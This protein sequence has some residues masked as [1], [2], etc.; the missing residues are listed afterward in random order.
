MVSQD[1]RDPN[2]F[3]VSLLEGLRERVG[4][5]APLEEDVLPARAARKSL[6]FG[7]LIGLAAAAGAAWYILGSGGQPASGPQEVPVV[8]AEKAPVKVR[9]ADPGGMDVPN[10]DKLVYNRVDQNAVKPE[11]EHLLP[12]P[13]QPKDLPRSGD[14]L[15]DGMTPLPPPIPETAPK[16][17]DTPKVVPPPSAASAEPPKPA[18]APVAPVAKVE[19]TKVA[20]AAPAPVA[21]AE[22]AK[23]AATTPAAAG[24]WQVQLGA[25]KDEAGAEAAWQ[26]AAKSAP[27]V[28]GSLPHEIIRADLGAKGVFYRLRA[29]GFAAREQ[30]DAV[31]NSLKPKGIGCV[32][33]KR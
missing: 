17:V 5:E 3:D 4:R 22:P 8:K 1:K 16:V 21:K 33:A 24:T 32:V 10:Q 14:N 19:P 12:Q 26:H 20:P 9:P 18:A 31:C 30:A 6:M 13:T 23:P 27:D 15:G 11:V 29:G 28:L 2:S 7:A 25:L